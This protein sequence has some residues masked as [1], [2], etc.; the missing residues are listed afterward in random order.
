MNHKEL[1]VQQELFA[2][3]IIMVAKQNVYVKI[4]QVIKFLYTYTLKSGRQ[5]LDSFQILFW[6]GLYSSGLTGRLIYRILL[7]LSP[8]KQTSIQCD[9]NGIRTKRCLTFSYFE[10]VFTGFLPPWLPVDW[11]IHTG[12]NMIVNHSLVWWGTPGNL[13]KSWWNTGSSRRI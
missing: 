6:V 2:H 7:Y 3:H 12:V 4:A 1:N 10:Q 5:A 9:H 8:S 11:C 13:F